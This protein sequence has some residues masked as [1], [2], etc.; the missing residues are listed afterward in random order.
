MTVSRYSTTSEQVLVDS[1]Y[2][3]VY[4]EKFNKNKRLFLSKLATLNI[5]YPEF[6]DVLNFDYASHVW[7]AGDRYYKLSFQHYG[8][9]QYWWVIAWFNK[10]PT[11]GHVSAGDIIRVPKP[12]GEVLSTLGY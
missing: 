1:D 4:S 10:K 2:K 7:S 8:D 9:P 3:K 5:K 6:S 11:E 12:I